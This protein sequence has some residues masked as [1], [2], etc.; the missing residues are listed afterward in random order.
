MQNLSS[1]LQTYFID[2]DVERVIKSELELPNNKLRCPLR[3][4]MPQKEFAQFFLKYNTSYG[5]DVVNAIHNMTN[6]YWLSATNESS[7]SV[8]NIL[9]KATQNMLVW[10]NEGL[11]CNYQE[12]L[13]WNEISTVVGEDLLTTS[14]LAKKTC[15]ENVQI[16]SFGWKPHIISKNQ[17]LNSILQKG[18]SELHYH[19]QGS[20]LCF[21][22]NWL[23]L[24][25]SM[26]KNA[27]FEK[28][29]T[30][31]GEPFYAM[32]EKARVIRYCLFEYI[33]N[34]TIT[35]ECLNKLYR[36]LK[37][38]NTEISLYTDEFN[39]YIEL[40]RNKAFQF[41]GNCIDYAIC[42]RLSQMDRKRYYNVALIGERKLLY[43]V[44]VKVFL[45]DTSFEKLLMPLYV[46]VLIKN[47]FRKVLE[48]N[49]K[50]K[51][52][53][54]FQSI[55]DKKKNFIKKDTIYG[56]L[57]DF[58]SMQSAVGNQP[59]NIL[60]MRMVPE[61]SALTIRK[62]LLRI[63]S[64][65][66]DKK[67]LLD[68]KNVL[69]ENNIKVGYIVHFIKE[70]E[71]ETDA[72]TKMAQCRN[73]KLREKIQKQADAIAYMVKCND[74][75]VKG[76]LC[77]SNH[78]KSFL[79]TDEPLCH[80]PSLIG[81]DAASSEF[82]CRPEVFAPIFRQLKCIIHNS[83]LKYLY[84]LG[85]IQLGRTYHVG[86][87]YYDVVDGL[88]AIDE[89]ISFMNFGSGDRLG[90]AVALGIDAKEYYRSRNYK[91]VLPKQILLDNAVWLL[92]KMEEY[93]IPDSNGLKK[94]LKDVFFRCFSEIFDNSKT[95]IENY[96]QAWMLRGDYPFV[97]LNDGI[98][99]F[100]NYLIN[101]PNSS[102]DIIRNNKDVRELFLKYHYNVKV[103]STG[104]ICEQFS[105]DEKD[106]LVIEK[107]QREM[108]KKIARA[109]IAIETNPSSN[110]RITDVNQFSEH[111]ITKFNNYGLVQKPNPYQ[112]DVSINTDDQG[113]F[114]TSLEKEFTL[115]ALSLE[116]KCNADG[117]R[118]YSAKDIYHWLDSIREL[119]KV[120]SFLS[121][122]V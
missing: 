75:L 60:E 15:T 22:V 56:Q 106:P 120:R 1:I 119:A 90:H 53:S 67:F 107:I 4:G 114:S 78:N 91:I 95:S 6:D 111:P 74:S 34:K 5:T 113:V 101:K 80:C 25:N 7:T 57:F 66:N 16:V 97:N 20:S 12:F 14:F 2:A 26:D 8:F 19:L 33:K 55:Q 30:R 112:I 72:L 92:M 65:I 40:A 102:L 69:I 36:V 37:C 83:D 79:N 98:I 42:D 109:K 3:K 39:L 61:N 35:S 50:I 18:L 100:K 86:E 105:C 85:D 84:H 89:C 118:R 59:L 52:F 49:D 23:S 70:P 47:K 81:I 68:N 44:F 45:S 76:C 24:M 46:Y 54:Y 27:S 122:V 73:Y 115:M 93:S 41:D 28:Q 87:D 77:T 117:K 71:K 99:K 63:N 17:E 104:V 48:Q 29:L 116:K 96:Y 51:G 64:R 58:L 43:N 32:I 13:R 88:R 108:R 10:E 11:Y 121:G 103:K 21:D 110:Y 38:S 9:V 62:Q 82:N 31:I 94:R